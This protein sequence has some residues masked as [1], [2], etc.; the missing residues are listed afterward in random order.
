MVEDEQQCCDPRQAHREP[1]NER[2]RVLPNGLD[3][4][5]LHGFHAPPAPL[6]S[7]PT[8]VSSI[9]IPS[10]LFQDVFSCCFCCDSNDTLSVRGRWDWKSP[11]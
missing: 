11:W 10:P 9:S 8:T 3:A 7:I 1:S 2:A 5:F 4:P 6:V